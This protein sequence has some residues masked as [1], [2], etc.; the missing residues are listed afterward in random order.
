MSV[1][2]RKILLA[3]LFFMITIIL[4]GYYRF[5]QEKEHINEAINQTLLRSV[6]IANVVVGDEYH[7]TIVKKAPNSDEEQ[8]ITLKLSAM[9]KAEG[10][11]YIYTMVRDENKTL[12][13]TS[14]SATDEE[15]R[16]Q[17]NLTHFYD[18]YDSD[19]KIHDAFESDQ[20]IFTEITDQWG[21]FRSI[22]VGFTTHDKHQYVVGVD[23]RVDSIESLSRM[24]ALK[25]ML[26]SMVIFFG[27]LPFLLLYRHVARKNNVLLAEQVQIAT[28]DLQEARDN[29]IIAMHHA[30]EANRAKDTFLS[31][32]SHELRT[33]LNAIIGFSQI[34]GHRPELSE[35]V[36]NTIEKI[37]ISGKNLLTL[38][39]TL[40]DFSKIEAGKMEV[41]LIEFNV[42]HLMSEVKILVE[43]LAQKKGI[44]LDIKVDESMLL[45][46]DR[47]L[48]KQAI[49]N[50]LTNAIKFSPEGSIVTFEHHCTSDHEVFTVRDQGFGI[51][52]AKIETLF[53][54]F[55]QIR[56]HQQGSIKGTGLG[57]SIV[58]K[59]VEL[60][61]G[62][63]WV[64]STLGEGSSFYFSLPK[65]T[66]VNQ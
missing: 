52:K 4:F 25:A 15:L 3:F 12:H 1:D 54:P 63:I 53:D 9:A 8:I 17:K 30:Q 41:Q 10:V 32:M 14:S 13:F 45:L 29:A 58:K 31:S 24:A 60:H 33:P 36:K 28:K 38:V 40:L 21:H 66:S 5:L 23:V 50:L 37:N 7:D 62:E 49:V 59:I 65:L 61:W 64:E 34:L 42:D 26:G 47:Q 16:T 56:E 48:I 51:E 44:T 46:A 6:Q 43:S 2:N 18:V 55:V 27:A 39:N 11:E 20:K 57:L 19:P 35:S 22:F